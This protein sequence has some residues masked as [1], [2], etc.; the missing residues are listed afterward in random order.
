MHQPENRTRILLFGFF[1]LSLLLAGCASQP[2]EMAPYE[3]TRDLAFEASLIEDLETLNPEAV[4]VFQEATN[5]ADAGDDATAA[6]LYVQVIA[7][8]P[9][10]SAAYRRLGYLEMF[11]TDSLEQAIELERKAVE[12]NPDSYSQSTLAWGLLIRGTSADNQEAFN[13]AS[14]AV[15]LTPDDDQ[16]LMVLVMAAGSMQELDLLR[17]TNDHLLEVVPNHPVAHYYKGLLAADDGKWEQ[18]ERELLLSQS[19]GMPPESIQ[20]TLKDTH[21]ARNAMLMRFF[22]WGGVA[23]AVWLL[24]LLVLS[25]AGNLLSRATL[26]S[27]AKLEPTIGAQLQPAERKIRAIYRV[28][29]SILSIYFYVSIPFVLLALTLLVAGAFYLFFLIGTIPIQLAVIL[30]LLLVA[31]LIA[32]LRS[33]FFRRK[34]L[35]PG[36]EVSR[37]EAPELWLLAEE[38]AR[39]S[40][41][42]PVESIYI[43]PYAGIAVNESGSLVRKMRGA[44]HRNLI[45]GMGA[46]LGLTQGELA[47]ILAH[48]YGHFNNR[49]T[50]GGD[51]AYRVYASLN[52]LAIGLQHGGAAAPYNPVWLFVVTY[53]RIFLRVTLGASRLQESQ[54]DRFAVMAYGRDNFVE[55]LKKVIRQSL[56]FELQA[57][58][59]IRRSLELNRPISNLYQL[60]MEEKLTGELETRFSDTMKHKA[61]MYASHPSPQE[62]IDLIDRL[63]TPY[64]FDQDNPAP[65]SALFPKLEQYQQQMTAEIY[66]NIKR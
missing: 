32:T 56:A 2:V 23:T 3:P 52:Q 54:A 47:S 59:E 66:K 49:D 51:L 13:L 39:K 24:G 30:I 4:P 58:F 9:T 42:R 41:T 1:L 25:L 38:A 31:S 6:R 61:S 12:L 33:L 48:E 29:I 22:L 16:A 37:A 43:T 46:F 20:T 19:L 45:L 10:F 53:Q 55:G 27:L 60:P 36:Q 14:A 64:S 35:Q 17:Q 62:R 28:V 7:M 44:G 34:E 5:A 57:N 65:V 26:R 8:A 15:K 11:Y 63:R 40:G 50:A 18:A 21:I